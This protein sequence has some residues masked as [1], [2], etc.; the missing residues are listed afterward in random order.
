VHLSESCHPA[1]RVENIKHVPGCLRKKTVHF[2]CLA[3]LH[4]RLKVAGTRKEMAHL[5]FRFQIAPPLN[6]LTISPTFVSDKEKVLGTNQLCTA[7]GFWAERVGWF[8][9]P[10][11]F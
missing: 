7:A 8:M 10:A 2:F 5:L 1:K 3:T 11:L 4:C 6:A 9:P